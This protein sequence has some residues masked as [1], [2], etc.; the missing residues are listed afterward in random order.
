MKI[1]LGA[2]AACL[3]VMGTTPAV[4]AEDGHDLQRDRL[5]GDLGVSFTAGA[6]YS[7]GDYGGPANTKI[8]VVPFSLRA[9]TGPLR[10][11]A[12]LP[13]LRIDGP[14]NIV[15]GGDGGPI[16]IDPND[17]T[18]REV[19]E[20]LGDLS[21]AATYSLPSEA[22]GG[23]E[24]DLGARVKLPTSSE[25]KRLGTG[26]TD[27]AVS[28]DVARPVGAIT[29]F[30]NVGYRM[31]GDPDGVELK[32]TFTT[33][34]GATVSAGSTTLIASYDYSEASSAL[35]KDSHS[36]FGGLSVPVSERF[37]LIGYGTGGL[38][39]GAADYGVGLLLS[40]KLF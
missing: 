27:F 18:P 12:T 4:A 14:G 28:V 22:L 2:L 15:G 21:L 31:P 39:E 36:L 38:S 29:P 33:S 5:L 32:N 40:A 25:R 19:R 16:V 7:V 35:A 11:S 6:D 10:I 37:S 8:L 20:G 30:V 26:K 17:P 23:F 1:A 24:V 9:K 34:V 3:A 13:Y